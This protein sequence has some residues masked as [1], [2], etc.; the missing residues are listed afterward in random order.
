MNYI[1]EMPFVFTSIHSC[2]AVAYGSHAF[3]G[4][5]AAQEQD[6]KARIRSRASTFD[7]S[8][9]RLVRAM[10]TTRSRP[11]GVDNGEAKMQV[12]QVNDLIDLNIFR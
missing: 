9:F 7:F 1:I 11:G 3:A 4:P 5:L 12:S 10:K 2:A 8:S 6:W